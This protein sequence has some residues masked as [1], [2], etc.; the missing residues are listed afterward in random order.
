MFT[1]WALAELI[2]KWVTYLSMLAV[3][4]GFLIFMLAH[5]HQ[6]DAGVRWHLLRRY[7]IPASVLGIVAVSSFFLIQVGSINQRG[8]A[9]MLDRDMGAL[10]ASTA[11]GDGLQWRLNGFVLALASAG[12]W[13][14]VLRAY[15]AKEQ[16][17]PLVM[18]GIAALF[19]CLALGI[20][21]AVLGHVASLTLPARVAVVLHLLAVSAWGGALVP[22][23]MLTRSTDLGGDVGSQVGQARLISLLR[24]YGQFGWA[25]IGVMLASGIYLL[26]QLLSAPGDLLGSDYGRLML[27]KLALVTALMTL[28][29]LNK[30][31]LVPALEAGADGAWRALC[32][33][34]RVE[35]GLVLLVLTATALF[36]TVVGP[37]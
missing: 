14:L 29:A 22:L 6:L 19:A 34:I 23:L 20:S 27:A 13:W 8:M 24:E 30:Y 32:R 18:A 3:P 26:W 15:R 7:L 4:G 37:V 33:S 35:L 11:L 2:S 25:F 1:S 10:L 21:L 9:G 36:T 16:R 17:K 12:L 31:R 28:G 5:R